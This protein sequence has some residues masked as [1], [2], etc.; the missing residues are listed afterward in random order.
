[1][2]LQ[3]TC[4][5]N[6]VLRNYPYYIDLSQGHQLRMVDPHEFKY[7]YYTIL[8]YFQFWKVMMSPP[9]GTTN[10]QLNIIDTRNKN[11]YGKRVGNSMAFKILGHFLF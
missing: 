9:G 5:Y 8:D 7:N 11:I 4:T 6:E 1:M 3:C 2:Q 10:V